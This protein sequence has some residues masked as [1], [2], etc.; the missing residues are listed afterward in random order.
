[1]DLRPIHK[2]ENKTLKQTVPILIGL[3]IIAIMALSVIQPNEK[4]NE[5]KYNDHKFT[6][7]NN[8]WITYVNKNPISTIYQ[9]T[10]LEDIKA[11]AD[12]GNMLL[13][14]K[15]YLS[16]DPGQ[17]ALYLPMNEITTYKNLLGFTSQF[18]T[19]CPYDNEACSSQMLP[20]K[21]CKD[22]SETTGIILFEFA[23]TTSLEFSNGCLKFSGSQE[24]ITK[25]IDKLIL[26]RLDIM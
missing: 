24:G 10:E 8:R 2:K 12:Y 4:D 11:D 25:I 9:P 7:V 22:A 16:F 15:V 14:N 20:I 3:F 23:N 18:I 13:S 6:R 19:A 26:K 1:M 17:Q 21:T 5:I